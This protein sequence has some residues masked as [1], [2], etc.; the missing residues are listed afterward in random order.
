MYINK[1]EV[2]LEAFL[3]IT[4]SKSLS[5]KQS[6]HPDVPHVSHPSFSDEAHYLDFHINYSHIN[7]PLYFYSCAAYLYFPKYGLFSHSFRFPPPPRPTNT[8]R[9]CSNGRYLFS[10]FH[11]QYLP[12]LWI[13]QTSADFTNL[14]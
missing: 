12:V 6:S 3:L 11:H 4:L 9:L 1:Y 8:H 7:C 14:F 2:I 5:L 10:F 13:L